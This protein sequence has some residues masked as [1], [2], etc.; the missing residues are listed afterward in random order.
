MVQSCHPCFQIRGPAPILR[1]LSKHHQHPIAEGKVAYATYH[2]ESRR[3]I[4]HRVHLSL[5]HSTRVSPDPYFLARLPEIRVRYPE[6][7]I[8][9]Q[10]VTF[11]RCQRPVYFLQTRLQQVQPLLGIR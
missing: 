2:F 10:E 1:R 11:R 4:G 3:S 7:K 5:R 6:R 9:L 8:G